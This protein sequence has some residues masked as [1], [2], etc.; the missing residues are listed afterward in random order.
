VAVDRL[1]HQLL[2]RKAQAH[3]RLEGDE[4]Q[5]AGATVAAYQQLRRDLTAVE[6][7][8]LQRL[9]ETH[10]V[11]DTTRRKLQRSLDLEEAGLGQ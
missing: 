7:A 10:E 11:S 5:E 8:E 3:E 1:R 9:C 2:A 4:A 6:A